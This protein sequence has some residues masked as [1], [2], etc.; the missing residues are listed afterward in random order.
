M[1]KAPGSGLRAPDAGLHDSGA[2]TPPIQAPAVPWLR[3]EATLRAA[4]RSANPFKISARIPE[5]DRRA[6][7]AVVLWGD[8]LGAREVVLVQRGFGAPQHAGEL[9]LPGGMVEPRDR[10]LPATA[11]REL[12][13]ELGVD[14]DLWEIG[15]F[16]DGVAKAQVRF[17]PV[18]FRWEAQEPAF[19]VDR[20]LERVLRL[21]LAPLLEA[22]WSSE[23][24]TR[25]DI[26]LEVPRLELALPDQGIGQIPLWGATA[27]VLKAWLD[28]LA[29]T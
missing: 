3:I 26:S 22:P 20:E 13:E 25:Q 16:P 24:L 29:G 4:Y 14:R 1:S 23:R 5:S 15:C 2:W 21:P 18:L 11:R 12:F 19:R 17:T 7:V 10:D 27:F 6:A 8:A 28:V 9:A